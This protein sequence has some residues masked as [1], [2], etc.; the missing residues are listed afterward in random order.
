M[1]NES[2]AQPFEAELDRYVESVVL[3]YARHFGD[4]GA[5]AA[6][7]EQQAALSRRHAAEP[8]DIAR[9]DLLEKLAG[10]VR[11]TRAPH[12]RH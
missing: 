2:T 8:V 5:L 7:M 10:E 6:W 1:R 9:A 3:S 4:S 11:N 12:G